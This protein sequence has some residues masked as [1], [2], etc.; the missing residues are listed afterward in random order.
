MKKLLQNI[1][2]I[3]NE[4]SNGHKRK[5]ITITGFKL[6]FK[7]TNSEKI[8]KQVNKSYAMVEQKIR[9]KLEKHEKI[10][11]LF[12]IRE[13]SK[14]SYDSLFLDMQKSDIFEPVIAVSLLTSVVNGI[15][16][17]RNNLDVSYKFFENLGYPVVKAYD[18]TKKEFIDLKTF[19]PD[20]LFYDQPWEIAEIHN[21]M[22]ISNFALTYYSGY[23]YLIGRFDADYTDN[24]HKYLKKFFLPVKDS[25][26]SIDE[27]KIGNSKNCAV[28]G[29]PKFDE[30]LKNNTVYDYWKNFEKIKIIY[31]PHHS[32]E[33]DGLNCA[34]FKENW[35][36]ILE[37]AKKNPQ[38]SWIFKPHPRFKF[39][40]L[41]N[42]IMTEEE[43]DNYYK[44]WA[45]IGNVYEKGNYFDIFKSSDLLITDCVSFRA[46]YLPSKKPIICPVK[47]G[48]MSFNDTGKKI[49]S[50]IY[51]THNNLELE[52]TFNEIVINNNDYL[53]DKRLNVI[54][55]IFDSSNTT[56]QKI[57]DTIMQDIN[58]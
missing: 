57:I 27:I 16:K 41:I 3:R 37:L 2:S 53:K 14:W 25:L 43:I 33:K 29:Y 4:R 5:I 13:C 17:T 6:K 28:V 12:L 9:Q 24:F 51:S 8:L 30:Y 36:F 45:T 47:D 11:V 18:E 55:E 26:K 40:L 49:M 44:E 42:N 50:V 20:I 10:K 46:E 22:H 21:I 15:D 39:A 7:V 52:N 31:A 38:T 19:E 23:G 34:T 35:Q 58:K 54:T 1:F 48:S 32:F 56:S